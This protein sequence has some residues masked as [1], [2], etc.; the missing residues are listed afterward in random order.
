MRRGSVHHFSHSFEQHLP[1]VFR[2]THD[3]MTTQ[4]WIDQRMTEVSAQDTQMGAYYFPNVLHLGHLGSL[5][6]AVVTG[7]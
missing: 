2:L 7:G 5:G 1:I 4:N 3:I 6:S